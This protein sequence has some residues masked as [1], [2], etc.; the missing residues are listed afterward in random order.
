MRILDGKVLKGDNLIFSVSNEKFTA[1]E[2]GTFSP[3]ET[4][5]EYLSAGDIGYIVTGIKKARYRFSW[6]HCH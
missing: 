5:R 1:L 6:G 2:V 3:E 4:E